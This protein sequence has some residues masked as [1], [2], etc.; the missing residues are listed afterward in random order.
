[1]FW[2]LSVTSAISPVSVA[3]FSIMKEWSKSLRCASDVVRCQGVFSS[4]SSSSSSETTFTAWLA[5]EVSGTTSLI[6]SSRACYRQSIKSVFIWP[7]DVVRLLS[8]NLTKSSSVISS[9]SRSWIRRLSNPSSISLSLVMLL[10]GSCPNPHF[11]KQLIIVSVDTSLE[12]TCNQRFAFAGLTSCII[13]EPFLPSSIHETTYFSSLFLYL[14]LNFLV[15]PASSGCN[16]EAVHF[17][18]KINLPF[19]KLFW[20]VS[21]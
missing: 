12:P 20:S 9:S 17:S 4:W 8:S 5:L 19:F 7:I 3:S 6:A 2:I 15:M 16:R 11:W 14:N 10:T 21:G 13:S 18:K 1:M